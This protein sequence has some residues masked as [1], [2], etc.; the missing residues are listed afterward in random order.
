[1]NYKQ[2]NNGYN[3]NTNYGY[4]QPQPAAN[5]YV[6]TNEVPL[7][8]HIKR[9][10]VGL[11]LAAILLFLLLWLFPTRAGLKD[12]ISDGISDAFDK[13]F[14]EK[15]NPLYDRIF[16]DNLNTMKEVAT[17][18]FTTD[19]LPKAEGETK[20]LTLGEMLEM[21][22]LR[23]IKDK[24]GKT[25]DTEKSYV[26][27]TKMSNE[28]KMKV[29]LSCDGEEDYIVVYLGCYNY[30]LNDV[31]EKKQ[32]VEAKQAVQYYGGG[33]GSNGSRSS[34]TNRIVEKVKTVI[35]K[36]KET[37][38]VVIEK[39][40]C[41]VYK[42]QYY[43][44]DGKV[45]SKDRFEKE[46]LPEKKYYCEKVDGKYYGKHGNVVSKSRFKKECTSHPEKHY[47]EVINGKYYGKYGTIVT[48]EQYKK[49][50]E[51][52]EKHYCV[53]YDGNYYG[54]HGDIVDKDEYKRQCE[55]E[56][57]HY[58]EYYNEKYYDKNGHVVDKDEYKRQCEPEK[59]IYKYQ[60][61]KTVD[62]HHDAE[63]SKWSDWSGNIE[64]NP[65]NNNINWG[66]HEYEINEKVGYKTTKY[67]EYQE[68][69]NQPVYDTH[70]D[71][72]IGYRTQYACDG[73]TYHIDSTTNTTYYTSV[74]G[75]SG[76]RSTGRTT[77]TYKPADTSTK[78]YVLV[79]FDYDKCN[80]TCTLKPYY[81]FD[82]QTRSQGTATTT[83]TSTNKATVSAVC[84]NVV[85]KSIPIY[86]K[87]T[88]FAGYVTNRIEKEKKTYYYHRK[89]RTL[90]REA[91]IER[92]TYIAWAY[93]PNEEYLI[94]QGYKYTGHYEKISN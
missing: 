33:S 35:I 19:R 11:L 59:E 65:D 51:P 43:G 93:S 88:T 25:C 17:A 79:G 75:G 41:G 81:I 66:T 30:C 73:Y 8:Y 82:V 84:S 32:V 53:Y 76:W 42:G 68:D 39:H 31:C 37:E 21:K 54:K 52:E 85:T 46:C 91:W 16:D 49:Q 28:Y 90:L 83:M 74:S 77:L 71:R 56:E 67:Y 15:L 12:V 63:Y 64:Y 10:L 9:F 5:N 26:E 27:I 36:E 57:K 1:M 6:V 3:N 45:V 48:P 78:R 7:S 92:K 14:A 47:C 70:F 61:K 38:T 94:N 89:T 29:N 72:I 22:L 23:S 69:R 87:R 2:T 4:V 55:P 44:K 20:K 86:G 50:C 60:Y 18:Y 58:C 40:I 80:S 62:I 34:I 13:T 24:N